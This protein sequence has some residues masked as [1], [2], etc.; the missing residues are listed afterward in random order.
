LV[1]TVKPVMKQKGWMEVRWLLIERR[2]PCG[3]G[4]VVDDDVQEEIHPSVVPSL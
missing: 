1:V 2:G 3:G 4:H